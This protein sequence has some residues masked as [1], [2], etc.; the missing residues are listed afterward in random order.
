MMMNSRLRLATGAL[1]LTA[2]LAGCGDSTEPAGGGSTATTADAEQAV[3]MHNEA[4]T[5]FAQMMIVHHEGAVEM[6][7]LAQEQ[8]VT[9]EVQ[10]LAGEIEEAQGPEIGLMRSWLQQW[11]EPT[12]ADDDMAGMGHGDAGGME[13]DGMSQ[14]EAMAELEGLSGEA[15][16]ARFLELMVEHHRGAVTMAQTAMDEGQQPD[17]RELAE[18]VVTDQEAE[19]ERMEQLHKAL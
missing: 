18:Q 13:M 15:F 3:Q 9:P 1:A 7:Q 11:G 14:E 8:A 17:V 4:D 5:M 16:D 10:E 19:I 6:A 12:A 2:F